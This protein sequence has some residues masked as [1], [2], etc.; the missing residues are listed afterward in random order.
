MR[1]ALDVRQIRFPTDGA[2]AEQSEL[3]R[4]ANGEA[5]VACGEMSADLIC[6]T[7]RALISGG[8]AATR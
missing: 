5:C 7:C 1:H 6:A 2:V 8:V 3:E 4:S